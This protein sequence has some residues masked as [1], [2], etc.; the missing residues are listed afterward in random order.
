MWPRQ[1]E[2]GFSSGHQ[3][4]GPQ[5]LEFPWTAEMRVLPWASG[6]G[7]NAVGSRE[8]RSMSSRFW[9]AVAETIHTLA[10]RKTKI[11]GAAGSG[12]V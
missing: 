2:G 1:G 3:K 4:N 7:E 5:T 10:S 11:M 9:S 8:S 12:E 6:A